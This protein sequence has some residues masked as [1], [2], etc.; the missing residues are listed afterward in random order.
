MVNNLHGFQLYISCQLQVSLSRATLLSAPSHTLKAVCMTCVPPKARLSLCARPSRVT[1][2]CVLLQESP[3]RGETTPSVVS[4]SECV[5]SDREC[6]Q[7]RAVS[8]Q[9]SLLLKTQSHSS[10]FSSLRVTTTMIYGLR[11]YGCDWTLSG[12]ED[13]GYHARTVRMNRFALKSCVR[14]I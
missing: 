9:P 12:V 14:V 13:N 11:V 7:Q 2:T 5:H 4:L 1:L 10:V 6:C 3:S 8:L